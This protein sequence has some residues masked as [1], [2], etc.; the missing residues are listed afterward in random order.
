MVLEAIGPVLG[1]LLEGISQ[2]LV[3]KHTALVKQIDKILQDLF[4]GLDISL[5]AVYQQL[6]AAGADADIEK[7]FEILDVLVLNAEKRV[8]S[9]GW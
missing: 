1:D 4:H 3:R 6:I 5:V 9:L 8:Q 2:F 7:R